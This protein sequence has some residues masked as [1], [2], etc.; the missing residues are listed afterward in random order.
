MEQTEIFESLEK[1][2]PANELPFLVSNQDRESMDI[3]GKE[4]TYGEVEFSS[5]YEVLVEAK[6][7]EGEIFFDLGSG[8]G[9]AVFTAAYNFPFSKVY[10]IE[11]LPGL[12]NLAERALKRA[13]DE[14][15]ERV[16][17]VNANFLEYDF[18]S[19]K[20]VFISATCFSDETVEQVMK[21]CEQL[22]L[23]ARVIILTRE[24]DSPYLERRFQ[25]LCQMGWGPVI[26][27][28]YERVG[29]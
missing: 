28:I 10:G 1:L 4:F 18:S 8:A 6:P 3:S 22:T 24:F 9:K 20:V 21:N 11:L 13:S 27:T 7:Q 29:N 25:K 15:K 12:Y 23:G 5:F 26:C 16:K 17:F 2:Y 19:A 14:V